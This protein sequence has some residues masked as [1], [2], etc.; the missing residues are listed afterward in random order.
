MR[1][2]D[3]RDELARPAAAPCSF[4]SA[5]PASASKPSVIDRIF[6]VAEQ[7]GTTATRRF[8]GLGLGLTLSRSIVEQHGGKLTASSRRPRAGCHVHHRDPDGAAPRLPARTD[9]ALRMIRARPR[10]SPARRRLK[11]LLVD[12]NADTLRFLSTMLGRRGHD[13]ATAGDMAAA[14]FGSQPKASATC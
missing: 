13:V 6:D 14:R 8:G 10:R 11:I 2:C 1:T 3:R 12:D 7:G 5:T 9:L 4:K